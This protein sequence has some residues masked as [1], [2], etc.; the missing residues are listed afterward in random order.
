LFTL[1]IL[2]ITFY[3]FPSERFCLPVLPSGYDE[4]RALSML[5]GLD[6]IRLPPE[7]FQFLCCFLSLLPPS[8]CAA[9][10]PLR[11]ICNSRLTSPM[12][13]S[14]MSCLCLFGFLLV[15]F[16]VSPFPRDHQAVFFS[17]HRQHPFIPPLYGMGFVFLNRTFFT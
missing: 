7:D 6:P 11:I 15:H 17:P 12:V 8:L 2:A 4:V 10:N 16:F 14:W 9:P 5:T 13:Y 3:S 1:Q